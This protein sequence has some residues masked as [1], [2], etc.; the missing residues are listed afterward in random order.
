[1]WSGRFPERPA[2]AVAGRY[3]DIGF[4]A[5]NI[6]YITGQTINVNG[7]WYMS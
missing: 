7:G 3:C 2:T 5:V 6:R 4:L 1:M